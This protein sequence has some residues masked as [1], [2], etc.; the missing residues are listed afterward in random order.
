MKLYGKDYT[1]KQLRKRV[2]NMDQLAAVRMVQLDEG[3]ER[4]T[5]AALFHTGSGLE[6][7]VLPDRCMDIAAARF[8]GKSMNWR[9]T[10]GDVAPQ[11]YEAAGVRWLRSYF[12]GMV[13]TCGL[14]NV[15]G[16]REGS[17]FHGQGLH[18]RI[19]NTPARNLQLVQEWQENQYVMHLSGTMREAVLFGENLSLKRTISTGLGARSFRIHDVLTNEGFKTSEYMLLYHCNVGF[20]AVDEHSEILTPSRCVA[21]RDVDARDAKEQWNRMDAPTHGYAEKVYFHDMVADEDGMV[22][23][24]ILNDGFQSEDDGFGVYIKYRKETLPRFTQWKM[25]GEQDYVVGLEPCT[26]GVGGRDVDAALGL[27]H[28]LAPDESKTFELEFGVVATQEEAEAIR[29]KCGQVATK[30]VDDYREFTPRV[31]ESETA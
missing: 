25:M 19:S 15:G 10:P 3:N 24:A 21:P 5:R 16:P 17:E 6:F 26:C 7:T 14:G 28:T 20:P 27:L 8:N 9:A 30:I 4:P 13:T 23:V 2:G 31:A 22:T 1:V 11:Y 29:L 18:G 12:G